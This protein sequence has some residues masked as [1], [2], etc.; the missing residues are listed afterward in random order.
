MKSSIKRPIQP[1]RLRTAVLVAAVGLSTMPLRAVAQSSPADTATA[2]ALFD[3]AKKLMAQGKYGEAC[4]KLEESQRLDP[5]TGTLL[6]MG[7]CYER[8]GKFATAWGKFLEAA[9][10]A[11]SAKQVERERVSRERAAALL[12]RVSNLVIGVAGGDAP[13]FELKRDG[14]T[15]GKPQWGTPLPVDS[16]EHKISAAA[17]GRKSWETTVV[18][19]A[20]ETKSISVPVLPPAGPAPVAVAEGA[21]A[22]GAKTEAPAPETASGGGRKWTGLTLA[23]AGLVAM[24]VGGAIAIGAKSKYDDADCTGNVCRQ[25]GFEDRQSAISSAR[26]AT[27]IS[28]VGMAVLAGGVILWLTAPAGRA[29]V[30]VGVHPMSSAGGGVS[31]TGA[32]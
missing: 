30:A 3:Q 7:D 22:P 18:L 11:K 26:T 6:N 13:G 10:V 21:P 27:I 12:P 14:A 5:G 17:T 31:L 32:W 2:Q 15:V 16:G 24:G 25:A 19:G 28:G 8:L 1:R 9:A 23:G 29:P 4:P 20:G